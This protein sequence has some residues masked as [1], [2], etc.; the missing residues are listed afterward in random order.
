MPSDSNDIIEGYFRSLTTIPDEEWEWFASNLQER[1][2]SKHDIW[3]QEG[4]LVHEYAFLVQGFMCSYYLR[5]NKKVIR[6]FYYGPSH[7]GSFS[8]MLSHAPSLYTI[9]ALED[10]VL[11]TLRHQSNKELFCRH[12]CWQEIGRL[13]A[14]ERY[15]QKELRE[16]SFLLENPETRY[17]T[18]MATMPHIIMRAPQYHIAS[19]LGIS[20]ET[21]SRIRRKIQSDTR[22]KNNRVQ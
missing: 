21:L 11:L 3:L 9:E 7:I 18:L 10:T 1:H 5:D 12:S 13:T 4:Q 15:K 20:P 2:L 22:E 8:G 17:R 14:E 6:D 16:A 19:Y